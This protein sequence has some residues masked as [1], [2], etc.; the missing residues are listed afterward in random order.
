[1]GQ[2]DAS[3]LSRYGQ[4]ASEVKTR[5]I[6][7]LATFEE[8]LPTLQERWLRPLAPEAWCPAQLVEHVVLANETFSKII[9]LLRRN[10]PLP[11]VDKTLGLVKN[12]KAQAPQNLQP[13]EPQS[14]AELLP[15]WQG[16]NM[17]LLQEADTA[18]SWTER[19]FFRPFFGDLAALDWLRVAVFHTR[20][21]YKQLIS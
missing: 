2:F 8:L 11:Q 3:F 6:K 4:D 7:E 18:D 14:L 9:Y 12:G 5:L 10:K 16:V 13:G 17:R 19:L 15:R 20:H 1:M 21:H